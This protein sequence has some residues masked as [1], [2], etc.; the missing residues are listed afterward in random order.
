[1]HT[2]YSVQTFNFEKYDTLI[3]VY[4][5]NVMLAILVTS[6]KLLLFSEEVHEIIKAYNLLAQI[7][8]VN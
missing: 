6:V 8:K 2:R 5:I 7:L 1:M 3:L 4:F